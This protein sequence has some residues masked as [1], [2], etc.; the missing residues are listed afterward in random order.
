MRRLS[1]SRVTTY[2]SKICWCTKVK[3]LTTGAIIPKEKGEKGQK[4]M[5]DQKRT[6]I[7]NSGDNSAELEDPWRP[8]ILMNWSLYSYSILNLCWLIQKS[9]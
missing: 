5:R 1:D 7:F 2:S 6:G 9:L 3:R 8:V 4:W